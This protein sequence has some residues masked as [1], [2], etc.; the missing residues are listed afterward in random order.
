MIRWWQNWKL[1]PTPPT[2]VE[3]STAGPSGSRK[4]DRQVAR[5]RDPVGP[6]VLL[7][8]EVGG[9]G[10]NFQ[11][12][13][14]LINY[15]LAWSPAAIEQRIGRLDRIGQHHEVRVHCFRVEG[16][17][18]AR[19]FDLM[20]GAVR[21][22]DE[23]VGGLDPVLE[24]VEPA[25]TKLAAA[26]DD[27]AFDAFQEELASKV[28]GAREE[29]RR[30]W[31]P[32]LDLRSFDK[33]AVRRLV[34]RGALRLGVE[35]DED[36]ELEQA[37]WH[38]ARDLDE[39][40]EEEVVALA[41]RV[42]I[43][44]D[45]EEHVE[46][47][48]CQFRLG[49]EMAVDQLPGV[50]LD[51]EQPILGSFWRDTAVVQEENDY[52]ATGHPLVEGLF[53]WARDSELGRAAWIVSDRLKAGA[54]GFGFTF[55][56][57]FPEPE[58]LATGSRVPSR[59]AARY[60]DTTRFQVGIELV[61]G[62]ERG[63]VRDDLLEELEDPEGA[64]APRVPQEALA[65]AVGIA[66]EAAKAEAEARLKRELEGAVAR[67]EADRD[68]ALERLVLAARRAD[69]YEVA[70]LEAEADRINLGHAQAVRALRGVRLELDQ[71]AGLLPRT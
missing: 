5:F 39:R 70:A 16:T 17:V 41:R 28:A 53:T 68:A 59:Q 22:F 46:A 57:L 52:F 48:Q 58:D 69:E 64:P 66:H 18:G 20:A 9:E 15:D 51:S 47:F 1:R 67:M 14:H 10:R 49:G 13:H 27:A 11:F 3:S 60:L 2:S 33:T 38:V 36:E 55:L 44:A 61:R 32:L 21:V 43:T 42:G 12:C 29:V 8:T 34:E 45:C 37:L 40:L 23:T 26:G 19:V 25:V 24:R 54:V 50:D 7:S 56:A 30:A 35:L 63:K 65:G 31:D 62:S 4:R 6:A 71:A